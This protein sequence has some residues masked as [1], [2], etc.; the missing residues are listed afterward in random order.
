VL[1]VAAFSLEEIPPSN[2]LNL[3]PDFALGD[4]NYSGYH[5]ETYL[6]QLETHPD[7]K[8][9][10]DMSSPGWIVGD[11]IPVAPLEKLRLSFSA[12]GT[13]PRASCCSRLRWHRPD[14]AAAG[15]TENMWVQTGT[16]RE[17]NA[18]YTVPDGVTWAAII[19]GNGTFRWVKLEKVE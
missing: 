8:V 6:T 18:T 17:M 15:E 14:G 19:V 9:V 4:T 2:L 13:C 7:G 16:D 1:F 11:R 5:G 12:V 10:L 3:N